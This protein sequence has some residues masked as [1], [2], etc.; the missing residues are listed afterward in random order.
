MMGPRLQSGGKDG[1]HHSTAAA[2]V[3]E[4]LALLEA[5]DDAPHEDDVD[6]GTGDY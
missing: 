5:D 4:M 6:D 3:A 1:S 2:L